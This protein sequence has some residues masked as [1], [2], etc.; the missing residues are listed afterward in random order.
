MKKWNSA[1]ILYNDNNNQY[2][3]L[4][5]DSEGESITLLTD[6]AFRQIMMS[7]Y[8]IFSFLSPGYY[9]NEDNE[10]V[11][12]VITK[13]DAITYFKT[14]FDTW[15]NDKKDG[16]I[17]L[18]EALRASYNPVNN[19]DKTI[20][21]TTEYSGEEINTLTPSG[22][23]S[24][25]L[26]KSG[27]EKNTETPTG[28]ETTTLTKSG[29]ETVTETPTGTETTTLTKSG[30]ET[31]TETPSGSETTTL[32][33]SGTE[34]STET[35]TGEESVT[36][37]IG[38]ATTTTSKPTFD[39]ATMYAT[40]QSQDAAKTNTDTTSFEDRQTETELSFT[41]RQDA[42]VKTFTNRQTE[43]ETAFDQ[44]EDAEVKSFT[45][46][47]TE[48]ETAFDHRQDEEVKTYTNRK[49]E[50]ELSFNNR[51]DT[52]VKTFTNRQD[53]A[54]KSFDDRIDTHD[55]HEYGNIGVTTSQQ[56]ITSQFPLTELDK[57]QHYIVNDF[58]HNNMI[59]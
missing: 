6:A 9:D 7:R 23:E 4:G 36:H 53:E 24:T 52:E 48:T 55:Y 30:T 10:W 5:T 45:D 59:I 39:S 51:Q 19:Y 31:V 29:T 21:E 14:L 50:N 43:T 27:S 28:T 49:T 17:K 20:H 56:M 25:T 8:N 32:T 3:L 54:V 1:Y 34:T 42:E 18:Y 16:Y 46:R 58:V 33:K 13:A 44:R 38:Q 35:P 15:M 11:D 40:E 37:S 47:Q 26:T 41:N 22:Q 2:K 57:L 12:L